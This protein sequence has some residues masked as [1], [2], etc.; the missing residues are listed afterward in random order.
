MIAQVR[1]SVITRNT[2]AGLGY[3]RRLELTGTGLRDSISMRTPTLSGEQRSPKPIYIN[4]SGP[5]NTTRTWSVAQLSKSVFDCNVGP[6]RSAT[7]SIQDAVGTSSPI[8]LRKDEVVVVETTY[9]S[10]NQFTSETLKKLQKEL[11]Q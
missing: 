3:T 4:Q 9:L 8:H 6:W 10:L 5:A 7:D 11:A 1:E 2:F